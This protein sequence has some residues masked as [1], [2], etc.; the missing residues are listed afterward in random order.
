M[1]SLH[2]IVVAASKSKVF[3]AWTTRD[4]LRAWWTDDVTVPRKA[5]DNYIFG[6]DGGRV[7]FHFRVAEEVPGE[8]TRWT[9]VDGA[10]I[11]RNGW[12]PKSMCG[13][14]PHRTPRL[15]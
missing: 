12:V 8:R 13:F 15:G 7:A 9:R 1:D 6:F 14:Q 2:E 10:N 11:P 5:G 4:G 3:D